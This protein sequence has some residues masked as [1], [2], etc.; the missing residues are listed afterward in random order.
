MLVTIVTFDLVNGSSAIVLEL[1]REWHWGPRGGDCTNGSVE[2][3]FV[4]GS[5]EWSVLVVSKL[6]VKVR[7]VS[8]W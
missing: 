8:K 6:I 5:A 3:R 7:K 1:A 4:G 2:R